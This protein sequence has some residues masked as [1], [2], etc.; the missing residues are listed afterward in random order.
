MQGSRNCVLADD[1]KSVLGIVTQFNNAL[2]D[3]NLQVISEL[4]YELKEN[5]N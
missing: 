4:N 1:N 5:K 2:C 3:T